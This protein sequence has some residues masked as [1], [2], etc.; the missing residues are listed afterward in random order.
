MNKIAKRIAL[1]FFLC[2]TIESTLII[3]AM[4]SVVGVSQG[5]IFEY[6]PVIEWNSVFVEEAPADLIELNQTESIRVTITEV[7]GSLILANVSTYYQNGTQ[8]DVEATCDVETGESSEELPPFIGAN[9]EKNDLVNLGASEPFYINET[10][11]RNYLDG[12]R[13]TNH[14][15]LN[16]SDVAAPAGEYIEIYEYYFD[17]STGVVVE[18]NTE[19]SYS[20]LEYI[21]RSKLTSSNVWLVEETNGPQPTYSPSASPA[22]ST[23]DSS[24]TLYVL[25]TV[26]A[27]VISIFAILLF[28]KKRRNK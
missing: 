5:N 2:F 14:L 25:A 12:P 27:I 15:I 26:A 13:E 22:G 20:G 21:T 8:K 6:D 7:S 11:T 16:Y 17:K 9:L 10:L 1:L 23:N 24:N 4:T 28:L 19:F 3:H 18:Y